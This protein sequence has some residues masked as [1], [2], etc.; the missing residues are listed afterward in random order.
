MKLDF[1]NRIALML[2]AVSDMDIAFGSFDNE[3]ADVSPIAG[4][5]VEERSYWS[6]ERF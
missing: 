6:R 4:A 1:A 3:P 5:A 2:I